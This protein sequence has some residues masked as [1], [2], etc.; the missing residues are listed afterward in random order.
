M[1]IHVLVTIP[2]R[3]LIQKRDCAN[4]RVTRQGWVDGVA[5]ANPDN[6]LAQLYILS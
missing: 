2:F 6:P 1:Y 5:M 4:R 3:D